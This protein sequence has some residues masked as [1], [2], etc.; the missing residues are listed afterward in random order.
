MLKKNHQDKLLGFL[1]SDHSGKPVLLKSVHLF[2]KMLYAICRDL[3]DGQLSL[4]AMS[5][6]YTTLITIVPLLA[7][8]FSVLKG[9]GVHNEIE[10][11][12]LGY[13]A[14]LGEKAQEITENIIVFVD[15]IKVGVLGA[16]GFCTL[17]YSV[18]ALMQKIES[19]FNFIW[20]ISQSRT[21][22]RRFS[23]YLS[24]LLFGPFL[25]FLSAGLTTTARNTPIIE[26]VSLIT[27]THFLE[28]LASIVSVIVPY[29]VMTFGFCFFYI[30]MPNTRVKFKAAFIGGLFAALMWKV[31]GWGFTNVIAASTTYVA[32]YAAF[33]TI[34]VFMIWLYLSWLVILMGANIAFYVQNPKYIQIARKEIILSNRLRVALGLSIMDELAD[35]QYAEG[36][37]LDA[38]G[39]GV[40]FSM[41]IIA[42]Q[43]ML[44]A[45][46]QGGV[47][48]NSGSQRGGLKAH[49]MPNIYYPARPL[50][51]MTL[52]DVMIALRS[53]SEKSGLNQD[54]LHMTDHTCDILAE[55]DAAH[56]TLMQRSIKDVFVNE[57]TK[58]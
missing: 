49:D 19:A 40:R 16:L 56:E 12:L 41:P 51:Q 31:M 30:Y 27:G 46:E 25:I 54:R 11:W 6:V 45:L 32:I 36:K 22:V 8:S 53:Y 48:V 2:V 14:P 5:L 50:D 55:M 29:I 21:L 44:D 43:N 10:P 18:I 38:E 34:I 39:L 23:D 1:S 37:G 9:F 58:S 42:I 35:N 26:Q 24:V 57:K 52:G 47:V 7:I 3:A 17:I 20:R 4:R 15:N 13:L 28:F 33:A